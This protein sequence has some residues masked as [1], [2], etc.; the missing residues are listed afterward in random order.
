MDDPR[1]HP[2]PNPSGFSRRSY[3]EPPGPAFYGFV[4]EI[5]LWHF[6][7]AVPVVEATE[8]LRWDLEHDVAD[9]LGGALVLAF[10]ILVILP[11]VALVKAA[12]TRKKPAPSDRGEDD[13]S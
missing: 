11:F 4:E 13:S 2:D 8:T 1:Y 6:T 7:D 10:K 12:V 3:W 9:H 5:Y